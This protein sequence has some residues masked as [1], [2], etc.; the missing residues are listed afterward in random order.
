MDVAGEFETLDAA[1]DASRWVYKKESHRKTHSFQRIM[2]AMHKVYDSIHDDVGR[3][4]LKH[5]SLA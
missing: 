4:I 5:P 3:L 1:I 2:W